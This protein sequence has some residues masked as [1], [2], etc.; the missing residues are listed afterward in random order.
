MKEDGVGGLLG[1]PQGTRARPPPRAHPGGLWGPWP[2]SGAHLLV[3]KTICHRKKGEDFRD[4][5]PPSWGVTW[6][7]ALLLSSRAILPGILPSGR[8]N[9]SH[10]HHQQPS[11]RGRTDLHQH[12]HQHHLISNPSSSLVFNLCLSI[13]DW[14]LWVASSVDYIL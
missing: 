1:A 8:G 13:S 6:A 3:Y 14:Y 12:L 7:G 4:G 2:A 5:V 9:R 10:H 11:Y